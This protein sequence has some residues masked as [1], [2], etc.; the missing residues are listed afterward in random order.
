M[1]I[2]FIMGDVSVVCILHNLNDSLHLAPCMCVLMYGC[3]FVYLS[4]CLLYVQLEFL[5]L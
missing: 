3:L 5:F 4:S 1:K 2:Y